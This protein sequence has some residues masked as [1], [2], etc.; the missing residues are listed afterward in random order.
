M[1]APE[2]WTRH[3]ARR[4]LKERG[5]AA[6]PDLAA[7]VQAL[8]PADP[9]FE[10]HRLEAL[11]A[12]ETL[13]TVE[14]GLL[15][16]CLNSPD[17][18]VRAAAVR[19]TQHWLGKVDDPFGRLAARVVDENPRVRLE[20]VRALGH[21]PDPK[22]AEIALRALDRPVDRF[23][24]YALWLTVRDTEPYWMAAL[25]EG[26]FDDGGDPRR[27]VFALESVGS[28]RRG[29]APGRGPGGRQGRPGRGGSRP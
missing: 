4:V 27:L 8:D 29:Q 9:D 23:L 16:V 20:A 21:A 5:T 12:Y 25:R 17:P 1:K 13:D 24:D 22:A 2:D 7:W 6:L 18:R 19:T 28:P 15:T 3:F 11:W 10:H 14:P 26:K